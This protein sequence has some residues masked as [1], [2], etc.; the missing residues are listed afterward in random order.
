MTLTI[1]DLLEFKRREKDQPTLTEPPANFLD[2][3]FV[4]IMR[5][6]KEAGP[7]PATWDTD[8]EALAAM[9]LLDDLFTIRRGKVSDSASNTDTETPKHLLPFEAVAW[10]NLRTAYLTLDAEI[11][12]TIV[13]RLTA[14]TFKVFFDG[15]EI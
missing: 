11:R 14:S 5:V 4:Y 8:C 7:H 10:L 15:K 13:P 6:M 3:L 9:D 1:Q 2:D 12:G